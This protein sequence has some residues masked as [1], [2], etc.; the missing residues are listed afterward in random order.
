MTESI[1][2][3][4]CPDK[5][6]ANDKIVAKIYCHCQE[7]KTKDQMCGFNYDS[8]L[9]LPIGMKSILSLSKLTSLF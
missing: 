7:G 5:L 2:N 4:L 6:T 3:G 9:C 1:Y 8:N